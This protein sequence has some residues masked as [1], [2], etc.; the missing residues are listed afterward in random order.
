MKFYGI[1][2][3]SSIKQSVG[4]PGNAF[5]NIR[6]SSVPELTIG[7]RYS[8]LDRSSDLPDASPIHW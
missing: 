1:R 4:N 3:E 8:S 6:E 7:F 5:A 2:S